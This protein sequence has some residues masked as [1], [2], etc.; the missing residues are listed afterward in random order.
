MI[1]KPT[2]IAYMQLT[3]SSVRH[4]TLNTHLTYL[5]QTIINHRPV[6]VT[7]KININRSNDRTKTICRLNT[8]HNWIKTNFQGLAPNLFW[9]QLQNLQWQYIELQKSFQIGKV[10]KIVEL[11][12]PFQGYFLA[13][14]SNSRTNSGVKNLACR[15]AAIHWWTTSESSNKPTNEGYA[16]NR[17]WNN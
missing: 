15:P 5:T 3:T 9:N 1:Q 6:T 7:K 17:T 8:W 13:K 10:Q 16:D 11:Q 14:E 12:K 4:L 2:T